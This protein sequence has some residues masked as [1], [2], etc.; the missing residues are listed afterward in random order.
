MALTDQQY[1]ENSGNW[2]DSQYFI[3]KYII[4]NFISFYLF[5]HKIINDINRFY[6]IFHLK[7]VV[8]ELHYDALNDIK[9]IELELSTDL[10][11]EL[12]KD[13]VRL[14]ELA[15]VDDRGRLH[16]LLT[17]KQTAMPTAYLQDDNYDIIFD[18][19]GAATTGTSFVDQKLDEIETTEADSSSTL[20]DE[21]FG[22]RFGMDPTIAN[23]NGKF[24]IDKKLGIIRFSSEVKGKHIVIKY[25]SDGLLY[26][27]DEDIRI[28]KM[29]EDY[30]YKYLV[31]QILQHKF[32]VQEYIVRRAKNEYFAAYKNMKIRM[33]EIHPFDLVQAMKGRNK[34]IK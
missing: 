30:I 21:F 27:D 10:Q 14:I 31:N 32:G 26:T 17:D 33:M 20:S 5:D 23:I 6:F 18:S 29:C 7:R 12:P 15:W 24:N 13:F 16:P 4:N 22:G 34:W 11:L 3:M 1:Y 25:I 2:G 19:E 8:Q 9:A 28:L